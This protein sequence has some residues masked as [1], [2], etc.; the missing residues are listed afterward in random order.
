MIELQDL[1]EKIEA[2]ADELRQEKRR[3][4]S[5]TLER[6]RVEKVSAKLKEMT[7]Q[8]EGKLEKEERLSGT[9]AAAK[10]WEK[11]RVRCMA[12][13]HFLVFTRPIE[14]FW[15]RPLPRS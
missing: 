8:L 15:E 6:E 9:Y 5:A 4:T 11:R 14:S 10:P 12:F 3:F 13:T 7:R 2:A 1:E